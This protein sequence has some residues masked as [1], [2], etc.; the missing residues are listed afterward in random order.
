[1][2][3]KF[4][5]GDKLVLLNKNPNFNWEAEI[6]DVIPETNEYKINEINLIKETNYISYCKFSV[7]EETYKLKSPAPKNKYRYFVN[8]DPTIGSWGGGLLYIKATKNNGN[9]YHYSNQKSD[10]GSWN[11]EDCLKHTDGTYTKNWKELTE[12]EVNDKFGKLVFENKQKLVNST[13][14]N[15]KQLNNKNMQNSTENSKFVLIASPTRLKLKYKN[16]RG[17]VKNY[18]GS[19]I[20]NAADSFVLYCN[21]RGIRRFNVSN[22]LEIEKE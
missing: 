10:S 13:R 14:K 6:L 20:E 11:I 8:I 7:M 2:K 18:S 4:K 5:K 15:N 22:I 3:N 19:L 17:E 9:T 16:R 1:M 12:S 21:G